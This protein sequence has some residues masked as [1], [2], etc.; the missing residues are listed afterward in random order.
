[1]ILNKEAQGIK[2]RYTP[3]VQIPGRQPSPKKRLSMTGK[4]ALPQP[5]I[6][7]MLLVNSLV[8]TS[9]YE[10]AVAFVPASSFRF[11]PSSML[12]ASASDAD[13]SIRFLGKGAEAIVR[14]GVVLLPPS[15]E[16]ST[17]LRESALFIHAMGYDDHLETNVI[18]GVVLDYPSAF[19]VGEMAGIQGALADNV[20]YR[21]GSHGGDSVMMLHSFGGREEIGSSGVYEGGLQEA[22]Q[23]CDNGTA[24]PDRFKFFFNYCQFG[25]QE[26]ED[27]IAEEEDDDAW[28]SVEVPPE[29]VVNWSWDRGECWKQLRNA[30]RQ[31]VRAD[32]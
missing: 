15:F 7:L 6:V 12:R 18:R 22:I 27:I 16:F 31:H 28:V 10:T 29:M 14:P 9:L 2:H 30:V 11:R 19:T 25:T 8:L 3:Q 4:R 21:G 32:Q 1:M 13:E 24:S 26:L 20:I 5:T 17:Y 23:A